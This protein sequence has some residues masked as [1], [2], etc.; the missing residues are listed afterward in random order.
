MQTWLE[1]YDRTALAYRGSIENY[2]F[3][4]FLPLTNTWM[5]QI[6]ITS[7][8]PS[9]GVVT[10]RKHFPKTRDARERVFWEC[11]ATRAD[12]H[13][14]LRASTRIRACSEDGDHSYPCRA[15]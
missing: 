4:H 9:L 15:H 3:V 13:E 10:Q 2:I 1:G 8:I 12:L 11:L 5:W 7:T 6:P 14:A